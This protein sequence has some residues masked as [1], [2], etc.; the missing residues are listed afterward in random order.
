MKIIIPTDEN[1]TQTSVCVSFGR[2]P[3]FMIYDSDTKQ[4]SFME[5][6]A[7]SSEGG[8]GIKAAQIIV[9][10]KAD[11]LLTPRCGDNAAKVLEAA[12]IKLYKT[13]DGSAMDNIKAFL[14]GKLSLLTE[15]HPGFHNHG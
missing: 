3:F 1:T 9:D 14:D 10:T 15:T 5:N 13:R 4:G 2:T 8:A 7:A 6:D 12:G 11:A